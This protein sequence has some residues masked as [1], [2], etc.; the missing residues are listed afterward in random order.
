[1]IRLESIF[2]GIKALL[3]GIPLG[4]GLS[5]LVYLSVGKN[6]LLSYSIPF[7]PIII[8]SITVFLLIT[9]LMRYSVKKC[10]NQNIIETIRNENI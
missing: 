1:M 5:Y 7:K 2:I 6:E 3:F 9:I 8:A 4:L 10:E